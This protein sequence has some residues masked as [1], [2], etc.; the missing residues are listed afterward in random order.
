[1]RERETELTSNSAAAGSPW[2][3]FPNLST[4]S[5]RNTG[6]LTPTAFK[7]LMMRPGMLPTYVR[8][9]KKK[10]C[11][12]LSVTVNHSGFFPIFKQSL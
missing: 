7:P 5:R 11:E 6:L 3:L 8:L 2:R 1:M 12:L 9:E 10:G 4:S